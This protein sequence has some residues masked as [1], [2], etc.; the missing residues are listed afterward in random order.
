MLGL[1]LVKLMLQPALV[2]VCAHWGFRLSG[3]PLP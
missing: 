2:L 3:L 1:V